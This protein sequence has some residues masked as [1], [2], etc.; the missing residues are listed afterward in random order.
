VGAASSVIRP[1]ASNISRAIGGQETMFGRDAANLV[2]QNTP[3]LTSAW[4]LRTAYSRL[5]AD[6]LQAFLD[7]EAEMVFRR[8]MK[9]LQKDYGTQPFIPVRGSGQPAR[10]PDLSNALG[11]LGD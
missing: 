11:S 5:V 9:R 1:V 3:F 8:R 4:Y 2:R 7:P 6:N 10:L